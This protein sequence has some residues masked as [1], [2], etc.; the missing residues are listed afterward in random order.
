MVMVCT[1]VRRL[2][3]LSPVDTLTRLRK[4]I[5]P[6]EFPDEDTQRIASTVHRI[7]IALAPIDLVGAAVM[8]F[9][10]P[11]PLPRLYIALLFLGIVAVSLTLVRRAHVTRGAQ[12]LVAGIWFSLALGLV[13]SRNATTPAL[14]GFVLAIAAAGLLLGPRAPYL[15]A[16]LSAVV[17]PAVWYFDLHVAVP[18]GPMSSLPMGAWI[19]QA[20][21]YLGAAV[22]V[23]I[24]MRHATMSRDRARQSEARFRALADHAPDMIAEFDAQ[25]H[26]VYANPAALRGS[27]LGDIGG[28][29]RERIG[30]WI[31]PE[32]APGVIERFAVLVARGGS[33]R[34]AYRVLGPDGKTRW[35]ESLAVRF[36]DAQGERRVVSVTRNVTRQR[37]IEAALRESEE[38]YRMLADH[39]PDMIVE[40]DHTGRIVYANRRTLEFMGYD[41]EELGALALGEWAHPD[42]F[43]ACARGFREV[44]EAGRPMRLV[45]RLRRK[46]GTYTWVASSGAPVKNA[47]GEMHMVAQSRD[48]TEE[49]S[50]QEQLRQAQKMDAIG[51][52]A[53]GVAHD[54]NNLLTVIGGYAGVLESVLPPGSEADAAH[55]ISEATERA[56]ALTRQLLL[57]SRRQLVQPGVVDLNAAIRGLEPMLRR[58]LPESIRLELSLDP[59]LPAIDIDPSQ[60]DQVMLNLAL[61]A[62]DAIAG[63]GTLRIETQAGEGGRSVHL[64]VSDD[65]QGM[66]EETRARAF[67][68]FFTT[69]PAGAGTG[70]GLSTTYGIV[71]QAQGA[72]SLD[73]TL[74]AGTTVE[75]SLP[76]ASARATPSSGR[77]SGALEP[78]VGRHAAV[79]LVED[80]VAVR[81]LLAI[82]LESAGYRVTVAADGA[83]ALELV[84]K[85][86]RPFDLML[87]DYVMPG[88]SGVELCNALRERWPDLR[89]VL[90]TGHAEVPGVG[91]SELP[92]GVELLG[93]PFTREQLQRVIARQLEIA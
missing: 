85:S 79:L 31:H 60:V 76:A 35:L 71:R 91:A 69:K 37:E 73:S 21:I 57:L 10:L 51:R 84:K 52:L 36:T 53:G 44:M 13:V 3:T 20:S 67:E 47:R 88:Q 12:V 24:A 63:H 49:L 78:R 65:G 62:R 42:D 39:A 83:E 25:G 61:N 70:L 40:H 75:I 48:L 18:P 28:L 66:T 38:R 93:K 2:G 80:D 11:R 16:G 14:S 46:D 59:E 64:R 90:M 43:E 92:R 45:H 9:M 23:S 7:G 77:S 89:V 72:I 50:L 86:G 26:F 17:G 33:S 30:A 82:L 68:P 32:D 6:P 58:T 4:L 19:V 56:A 1:C 55:E 8:A 54:F 29:A 5:A 15:V 81:R 74:G 27:R 34:T 87:T 41:L 22:L